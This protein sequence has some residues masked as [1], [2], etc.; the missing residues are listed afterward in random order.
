M[1]PTNLPQPNYAPP[2]AE[3]RTASPKPNRLDRV[4]ARRGE[5]RDE[6][7]NER[8]IDKLVDERDSKRC[9]CCG[10]RGRTEAVSVFDRLHRAHIV[11]RSL[12]GPYTTENIL[13]LCAICHLSRG[14]HGKQ[15][16]I[17]GTNANQRIEFEVLEAAVVHIFGTRQLPGHVRI[18]LPSGEAA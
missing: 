14:V 12:G 18:I 10:R 6:D 3:E 7:A 17:V 11:D 16:F 8:A 2:S 13:L 4:L 9:R 15:L 5:R 1:I